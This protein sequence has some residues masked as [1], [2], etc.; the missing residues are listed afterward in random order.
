MIDINTAR[1][2]TEQAKENEF[3]LKIDKHFE[4]I[5]DAIK[6]AATAGKNCTYYERCAT[7]DEMIKVIHI[8]E[9]LSY[10]VERRQFE[11]FCG[12]WTIKISW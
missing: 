10:K 9:D 1:R 5:E 3:K 11:T 6:R 8:L 7:E 12:K 2:L 4:E